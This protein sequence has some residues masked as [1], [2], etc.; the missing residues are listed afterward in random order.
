MPIHLKLLFAIADGE[1]ARFVRPAEEDNTLNSSSRI[2]PEDGHPG[3]AGQPHN[4][5][6]DKFAAWV[7]EQ[8]NQNVSS[9]DELVVVA[10]AHTLGIIR[11]H[12]NK[13]T[14][15]KLIGTLDKDLTKISDH[16]LWPHVKQWV[17]PVHRQKVI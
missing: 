12:L 1:H 7:A 6:K 3:E 4:Q 13:Q 10:P 15:A 8:L 17:R 11:G 9:Y 2:N 5:H 14:E 16:D